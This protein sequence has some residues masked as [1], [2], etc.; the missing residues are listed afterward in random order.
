M[1]LT[2]ISVFLLISLLVVSV[3]T[4]RALAA[5]SH[6]LAETNLL[7]N[8]DFESGVVDPWI[9]CGG[10]QL[11]DAQTPGTTAAMVHSG[12]YA[13]RIGTPIDDSCGNG[14]LGP[15]QV[16][17]EDVTIPSDARDLTISFWLSA[18]GDWPAGQIEIVWTTKPTSGLGTVVLVDAIRMDELQSGWQL[19]RQNLRTEALAAV[20]GQTLY[21]SIYVNFQ[22]D[23][24]W[25]WAMHVDE[26]SVVPTRVQ[27]TGVALPAAL[28]GDG[29]QPLVLTGPGTA[30]NRHAIF[31]I[32][33]IKLSISRTLQ[34]ILVAPDL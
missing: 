28:R 14:A 31:R 24:S 25:N 7:D 4:W 20:R 2:W 15:A 26:I 13:L 11:V 22:G 1:K 29:T 3:P 30:A 5:T 12:R 17:A 23:P 16:A 19:Y 6:T 27:T 32:M 10:A 33:C 9:M 18:T 8:G 21:L 34:Q